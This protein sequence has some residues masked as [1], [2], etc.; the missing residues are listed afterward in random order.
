MGLSP[1]GDWFCK[2][3]DDALAGLDGVVKLVDDIL[4]SAP[5]KEALYTRVRAV[6]DRCRSHGITL[7]KK[8]LSVGQSVEF[9]GHTI[10]A[11]GVRP[12]EDKV[13]AI[14]EFPRP[15]DVPSLRSFMGMCNQL[16]SFLPDLSH[17]MKEM[18]ELLKKSVSWN[19]TPAMEEE[20][21]YLK[22]ILSG[23]LLVK[24]YDPRL[25]STLI[26]DASDEGLG[27]VLTQRQADNTVGVVTCGSRATSP[28]EQR[29]AP[30]E[31]ETL[32]VSYGVRKC[33]Y[34]L[35]G[36]PHTTTVL[37][38]HRP[39][40]GLFR[41]DLADVTNAR[42]QRMREKLIGID[43]KV[44]YV[45]GKDNVVADALSRAP[46][47]PYQPEEDEDE[48]IAHVRAVHVSAT[49]TGVNLA[50][51]TKY[52]DDEYRSLIRAC[53]RQERPTATDSPLHPYLRVW[54]HLST[55][56]IGEEEL[57]ICHGDKIVVP[58]AGR[59]EVLRLLHA[60]HAGT[61]K[62]TQTARQFY[63]WPGMSADIDAMV[64]GCEACQALRPSN[65]SAEVTPS[66]A[67]TFPMEALGTDI[68]HCGGKDWLVIVD[69]YSGFPFVR[70]LPS[71]TTA[72]VVRRLDSIFWEFGL[73][74]RLRSDGG[75]QFASSDFAEYLQGLDVEHE[76]SSPYNPSSN[77]LAEAAVK[78]VKHLM[79]KC[80][81]EDSSYDRAL[82][83]YRCTARAD[84][85]SPFQMFFGRTGKSLLPALDAALGPVDQEA[86]A[87]A[88]DGAREA[89][90]RACADRRRKCIYFPGDLVHVQDPTSGKWVAGEVSAST[91]TG[92]YLVQLETGACRER[93]EKF[94]RLR[95]SGKCRDPAVSAPTSPRPDHASTTH[96]NVSD[97][98]PPDSV[99][100]RRS[101]RLAAS[102]A[103][104]SPPA[105]DMFGFSPYVSTNVPTAQVRSINAKPLYSTVLAAPPPRSTPTRPSSPPRTPWPPS[106]TPT[107]T[108]PTRRLPPT[109]TSP[110]TSTRGRSGSPSTTP[111][112]GSPSG[113]WRRSSSAFSS[114]GPASSPTCAASS[115]AA[116]C[117]SPGRHPP[118][119]PG[120]HP[121][122]GRGP[123][124]PALRQSTPPGPSPTTRTPPWGRGPLPPQCPPPTASA[125]GRRP[126]FPPGKLGAASGWSWN[127]RGPG[128]APPPP[129]AASSSRPRTT[130][131][132]TAAA[133]P[134]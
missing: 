63:F 94:L 129:S 50:S 74:N 102:S 124:Y 125:S 24:H 60:G 2:R 93:N 101:P 116:S 39:L 117:A 114:S 41:R 73:P 81:A 4:V 20:F 18:R 23:P 8:K 80:A 82:H 110:P 98:V 28:T 30:I 103:F 112:S 121:S 79:L 65:A 133:S 96:S 5:T 35:R 54:D 58:A 15:H 127:P 72:A 64:A 104:L 29:Y 37:T 12:H 97:A 84:G 85:Y 26:T 44:K 7:S 100:L 36:N 115:T 19:W 45:P 108:S 47:F 109:G 1:S 90:K 62:T 76:I 91:A 68:F 134:M 57:V 9:A 6:L 27:F 56:Q 10:D 42:V 87:A 31:L 120:G 49:N 21:L 53:R 11:D 13:A 38:D 78:Q 16:M 51:I 83:A 105:N 89:W 22:N 67:A 71:M 88:R 70:P 32:G 131:P 122:A 92:S 95:K 48:E 86:A 34:Y 52:I 132:A 59:E 119:P 43:L 128:A 130:W 33:E 118:P 14:R 66:P 3:T 111:A 106:A 46:L 123:S 126:P 107:P 69:R 75:P 17:A 77:G 99:I 40:E 55:R 61:T 113:R 25:P